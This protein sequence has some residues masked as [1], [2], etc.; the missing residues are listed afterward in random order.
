MFRALTLAVEQRHRR[1]RLEAPQR[2]HTAALL[3]VQ[4]LDQDD[5][6]D[7]QKAAAAWPNSTSNGRSRS[8]APAATT[9][10]SHASMRWEHAGAESTCQWES[11]IEPQVHMALISVKK[12]VSFM[13][14]IQYSLSIKK[15]SQ[16]F[17]QIYFHTVET[18]LLAILIGW[19]VTQNGWL[20]RQSECLVGWLVRLVRL[21]KRMGEMYG[22]PNIL[23]CPKLESNPQLL[24]W[25]EVG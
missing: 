3:Q 19:L 25:V 9:T 2:F 7:F 4:Q 16:W 17:Y 5:W 10:C 8:W 23:K 15:C 11:M 21:D 12:H 14:F 13:V 18:G 20:V 1:P 6:I 24:D 22:A